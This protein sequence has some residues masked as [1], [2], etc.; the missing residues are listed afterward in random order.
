M[1]VCDFG[2]MDGIVRLP[3][4]LTGG[5]RRDLVTERSVHH[6][7][8]GDKPQTQLD[9]PDAVCAF[10]KSVEAGIHHGGTQARRNARCSTE[11]AGTGLIGCTGSVLPERQPVDPVHPVSISSF[12][13]DGAS[14][15]EVLLRVAVPPCPRCELLPRPT[16]LMPPDVE[17]HDARFVRVRPA[18]REPDWPPQAAESQVSRSISWGLSLSGRRDGGLVF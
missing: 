14:A 15:H 2:A 9:D 11:L 6:D 16:F 1:N 13:T 7:D 4:S 18:D 5:G 10:R 12:A 17:V 8:R 3:H